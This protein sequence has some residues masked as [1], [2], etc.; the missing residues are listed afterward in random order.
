MI[1]AAFLPVFYKLV[2]AGRKKENPVSAL[3]SLRALRPS[4]E[5]ISRKERKGREAKIF[6]YFIPSPVRVV[7]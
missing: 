6:L 3:R 4:R 1:F 5:I 7:S 2:R